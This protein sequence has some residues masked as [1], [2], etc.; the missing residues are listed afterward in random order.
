MGESGKNKETSSLP[1]GPQRKYA[2]LP[3]DYESNFLIRYATIIHSLSMSAWISSKTFVLFLSADSSH[4]WWSDF[5]TAKFVASP[6]SFKKRNANAETTTYPRFPLLSMT[7]SRSILKPRKC[8][9][10]SSSAT[11]LYF[12]L[13]SHLLINTE[14]TE[15]IRCIKKKKNQLF[16]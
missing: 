1:P 10:C 4:T 8:W 5:V 14:G 2:T 3:W 15:Y 12:S 13:F 11:F 9:R 6:S 7:L 16:E